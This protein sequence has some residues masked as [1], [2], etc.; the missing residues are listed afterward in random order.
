MLVEAVNFCR[1]SKILEFLSHSRN[2]ILWYGR[3][4]SSILE[5]FSR[6]LNSI[7]SLSVSNPNIWS[8][9][10][11][12]SFNLVSRERPRSKL[13]EKSKVSNL[14]LRSHHCWPLCLVDRCLSD[15][16]DILRRCKP[17]IFEELKCRSYD[18]ASCFEILTIN[19]A[20]HEP[21]FEKINE[22]M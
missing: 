8:N 20:Q 22:L 16:N 14:A 10:L 4:A 9:R 19:P 5:V 21:A 15:V 3:K 2:P 6:R 17:S 7:S 11:R 13:E 18:T 1:C 12:K